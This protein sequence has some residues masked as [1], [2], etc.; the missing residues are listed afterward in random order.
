MKVSLCFDLNF[1]VKLSSVTYYSSC[2]FILSE[3]AKEF[4]FFQGVFFFFGLVLHTSLVR[5][6][7]HQLGRGTSD[8]HHFEEY[9]SIPCSFFCI[10]R[11]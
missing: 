11:A 5:C 10:Q 2:R 3:L 9:L 6:R 7:I 4:F 8:N 1:F